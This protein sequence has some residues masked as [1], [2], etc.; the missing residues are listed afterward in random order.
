MRALCQDSEFGYE[1]SM[2]D[3]L[4]LI[5]EAGFDRVAISWTNK[6]IHNQVPYVQAN[7]D[8][9]PALA[10]EAG[11]KVDNVHCEF[12]TCDSLWDDTLEGQT[13]F[14]TINNTLKNCGLRRIPTVI[15]HP[16]TNP[17]GGLINDLGKKRFALLTET[18]EKYNVNIAVENIRN[19]EHL[20]YMLSNFNSKK[21]GFCYDI[22][23]QN[24]FSSY[25]DVLEAFGDRLMAL[26]LHDNHGKVDEHLLPF[27]GNVD[28]DN[29]SAAM[30]KLDY[31][32]CVELESMS[33][34]YRNGEYPTPES[35]LA[36]SY[37][38]AVQIAEMLDEK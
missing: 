29:F 2:R 8:E 38:R 33:F 3:R 22:G 31:K 19:A 37:K 9:F 25:V 12:I 4:R 13:Y 10:E 5:K 26:H 35:Y 24:C 15:F 21:V 27:D 14:D 1:I 6:Y 34:S 17:I 11:L 23:H 36:E 20:N 28:W 16:A 7:W 30:Q 32:G 18:A